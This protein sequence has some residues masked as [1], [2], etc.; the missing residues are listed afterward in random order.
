MVNSQSKVYPSNLLHQAIHY[1]HL[2]LEQIMN[3]NKIHNKNNPL[4]NTLRVKYCDSF[5]C[6]L[7]GYMFTSVVDIQE[8]L[9][10]VQTS[11]SRI[12][13]SIHMF[14]VFTDLAVI[15][16]DS[17]FRVVDK[18]LAKSWKPFYFPCLPARYILEI[19]PSRL[20]E[21]TVGDQLELINE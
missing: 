14:F 4:T 20:G 19:N 18:I 8:G 1:I 12:F 9:L 5:L 16:M 3:K 2:Y 21:F 10:L 17:H 13:S 7:I 11:E 15:W 6:Q